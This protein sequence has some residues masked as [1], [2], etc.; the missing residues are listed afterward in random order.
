MDIRVQF[1]FKG[2]QDHAI[3]VVDYKEQPCFIFAMLEDEELIKEFG[4]DITIK[5]DCRQ[6]LES[7]PSYHALDGL[8][9][10]I[11]DGIKT[12]KEFT[13]IKAKYAAGKQWPAVQ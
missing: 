12:T 5:T 8:R 9:R 3:A 4:E 6:V 7:P 2:L 1:N 10:A 11:F 13:Y